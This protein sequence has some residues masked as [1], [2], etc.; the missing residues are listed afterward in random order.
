MELAKNGKHQSLRQFI[1]ATYNVRT[2][3]DTICIET[4]ELITHKLDRIIADCERYDIDLIALQ[5]HRLHT[6]DQ[7]EFS[8]YH[9]H[10]KWT[11]AHTNSTSKCHGVALL[12]SNKIAQLN[13][14]V[15][16]KSERILVMHLNG[17][18]KVC[19]ISAYAPTETADD[20]EKDSFYADMTE[21]LESI[22]PHTITIFAGD[23]NARIGGDSHITNPRVV[24]NHCYHENT[25][26]N[27]TRLIRLCEMASLRP[28]HSWFP[29]RPT[30]LR[31]FRSPKGEYYQLDHIMFST[32][33]WTSVKDCRAY[34]TSNIGS[35]HK[36]VSAT[37]KLCLRK[38]KTPAN[39]RC[40]FM[41]EK[42]KS[43]E[44]KQE[45]NLEVK[46]RFE[47]LFDYASDART[48][49][50]IQRRAN[51]LNS[52]LE[53]ACENILGKRTKS[54]YPSW[55]SSKTLHQINKEGECKAKFKRTQKNEDKEAW[56]KA[57]ILSE[58]FL[59]TDEE[60]YL[61]GKLSALELA[62]SKHEHRKVWKIIKDIT[63]KPKV[64][65][66]SKVLMLDGSTP[67]SN[68]DRL[69][70]WAKYFS[71]LL[72]NKSS[73]V[74]LD[75]RPPAAIS[76]NPDIRIDDITRAE[77][78][79]A[80]DNL[81]RNKAPGPDY[82]MT[83]EVLK[84]GGDFLVNELHN[85]CMLVYKQLK[86]P[87]Q[88]TTSLINP[89]P[90]K[91]NQLLMTNYRGISLMSIAAKVYNRVLLNRIR[92]PIDKLLRSN[93]AGF[94]KGRGCTQQIHILR[95]IIEGAYAQD[96]P[97]YI[98][99]IDFKKA[100]DSVDR[101]MMFAILRHY[102]IPAQI[103]NAIRVMYDESISR[104]Y[105]GGETSEAFN[106]TTGVLQGDVLA[107]FLFIIVIDYVSRISAGD[108]GYMT[109]KGP[110]PRTEPLRTLRSNTT[111]NEKTIERDRKLNDLAFADDIAL[112]ENC[113]DKAQEQLSIIQKNASSVGL[114]IN[115]KKTEQ[116][117]LNDKSPTK[118]HLTSDGSI[119]EVV[120][121]FKYLGSY[122]MST[123]K[124]VEN[125]IAL[126]WVVFSK[127]KSILRSPKPT[128]KFKMRL[129]KASCI[130]VLLYGCETWVLTEALAKKL[131]IFARK[132][133]R[134][135]LDIRQAEE[136]MT[137]SELY[138]KTCQIPISQTIKSRQLQFTGHCLRL[139]DKDEPANIY[140][141][142]KSYIKSSNRRGR[143]H[144][145][146]RDQ[147]FKYLEHLVIDKEKLTDE[148]TSLALNK[149]LWNSIV[150]PKQP[151][152]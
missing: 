148:V 29:N 44:V 9:Q 97:L 144:M 114:E 134:I 51:A 50:H 6:N 34:N 77:V 72:N 130:S 94:R 16:Y 40:A 24:G 42:L 111:K 26:D 122:I 136:H 150:V 119:I 27:G 67:N 19:I 13:P 131:D 83:A 85:I 7:I 22:P 62:N 65:S 56:Q 2:L 53:S 137:N 58:K 93:Q 117:Q 145:T 12:Y 98:T 1:V 125:R 91:G 121:D 95:R 147:V 143:P 11:L 61:Q 59:Q 76:D 4:G 100:F 18:P 52:A 106:I 107:P 74:N 118:R 23:L 69:S 80:I 123:E 78:D 17:N 87:T 73:K 109:H 15:T 129:F 132:C 39:P 68:S 57:Q 128:V 90:K 31:T 48:T 33:W 126:A 108:F 102:G 82:A 92:D 75:N 101:E 142:Y 141:L 14:T 30:R 149:E 146:Y 55:I 32:K 112:L 151:A 84:D 20:G 54:K 10:D 64:A 5:E 86:A 37:F 21:L 110:P 88:W 45:F 28:A 127:L 96:I 36:I 41:T 139:E 3:N 70:E 35:D 120:D 140:A 38:T 105:V 116:I 79:K 25:N 152:R 66:S 63:D 8:Y 71:A 43:P 103:V 47:T 46:N 115:G 113:L 99:F 135:M 138:R 60:N 89:I 81:Q 133:Y 104:V 49:D 124:D